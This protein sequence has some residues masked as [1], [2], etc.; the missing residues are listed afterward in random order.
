MKKPIAILGSTV[1][2]FGIIHWQSSHKSIT[3]SP[4]INSKPQR[5]ISLAPSITETIYDLKL[6]K[7]L[8][9]VTEYCN[10]PDDSKNKPRI[11]NYFKVNYEAIIKQNPDLI[12]LTNTHHKAK[13][14][15][16]ELNYKTVMLK[17]NTLQG[18]LESYSKLGE[19]FKCAEVAK[20]RRDHI[21]KRLNTIS[22]K[23]KDCQQPRVLLVLDRVLGCGELR[24]I[25][26]AGNDQYF[27]KIL[28]ICSAKNAYKG[29]IIKF[30]KVSLESILQINPDII[31]DIC[32]NPTATKFS[33]AQLKKDWQNASSCPAV[34]NKKLFIIRD[35]YAS[36][37]GPRTID[38]IEKLIPMLHPEV[39]W[40]DK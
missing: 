13:E 34:A 40:N 35:T 39:K 7:Y 25:Y 9:G 20:K 1:L 23:L 32:S 19:I 2:F 26:L 10:Y 11:G 22:Q 36:I 6:D 15:L 3:P 14:R 27:S 24:E 30:P 8:V 33:D 12:I 31:I 5:V 21:E 16:T 38:F 37:P 28:D 29:T 4:A 17:Q 18:I